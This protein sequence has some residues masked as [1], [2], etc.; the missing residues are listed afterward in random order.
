MDAAAQ[1]FAA[2][3]EGVDRTASSPR[4]RPKLP[5]AVSPAAPPHDVAR[6]ASAGSTD[7]CACTAVLGG[8]WTVEERLVLGLVF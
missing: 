2:R 3:A 4:T 8:L 7:G 6:S 5:G 1:E